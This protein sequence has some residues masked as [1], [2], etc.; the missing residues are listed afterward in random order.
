VETPLV[1]EV[2]QQAAEAAVPEVWVL[3]ET[4]LKGKAGQELQLLLP[5]VQQRMQVVAAVVVGR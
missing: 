1:A 5:E 4:L 2:V 3:Q